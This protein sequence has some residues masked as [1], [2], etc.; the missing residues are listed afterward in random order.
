MDFLIKLTFFFMI[1]KD[2]GKTY[3]H[4]PYELTDKPL[5]KF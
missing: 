4:F 3:I 5:E 2:V 1:E